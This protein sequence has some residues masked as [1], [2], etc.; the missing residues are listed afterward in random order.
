[1]PAWLVPILLLAFVPSVDSA[2]Q[3]PKTTFL[4][5]LLDAIGMGSP[6]R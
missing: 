2:G 3:D 6:Q 5:N 4:G 1:M